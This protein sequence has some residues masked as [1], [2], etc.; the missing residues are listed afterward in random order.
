MALDPAATR[1]GTTSASAWIAASDARR[2]G[3]TRESAERGNV[4]LKMLP[5]RAMTLIGR[6]IPSFCGMKSSKV[7]SSRKTER[8]TV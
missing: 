3:H 8:I 1:S 2:I 7:A 4:G 6:K 5:S